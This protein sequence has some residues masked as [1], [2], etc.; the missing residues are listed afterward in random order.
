MADAGII[1]SGYE[2]TVRPT[3]H[4][5]LMDSWASNNYRS[6]AEEG[7]EPQKDKWYTLKLS[8]APGKDSATVRGKIWARGEKEPEKWTLE[9]V[10]KTPNREGTPGVFANTGD[11]ELYLD[12]LKVTPN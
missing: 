11:A 2:L 10:D 6:H 8:V 5:L 9:M 7:F 1:A 3:N 12:N 4:K